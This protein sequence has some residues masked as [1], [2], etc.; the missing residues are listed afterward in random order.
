M[1]KSKRKRKLEAQNKKELRQIFIVFGVITVILL[2]LMY[3]YFI[4]NS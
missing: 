1:A 4:N 2:V 3:F